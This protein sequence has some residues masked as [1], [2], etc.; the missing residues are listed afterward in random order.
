MLTQYQ[1]F[2]GG[3]S[4]LESVHRIESCLFDILEVWGNLEILVGRELTK[5]HEEIFLGKVSAAIE[6]CVGKK[7]EFIFL[8]NKDSE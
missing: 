3:V 4:I 7:G 8:I 2:L 1:G 6:W 5:I